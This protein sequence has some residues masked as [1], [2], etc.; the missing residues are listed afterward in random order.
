MSTKRKLSADLEVEPYERPSGGWGSVRSLAR[1]LAGDYVPFTGPRVLLRQNKPDGF[2]C[3]SCAWAKPADPRVFEFCENGAKATTWEIT[4]KRVT[5][6]FFADKTVAE[7]ETWDDHHLEAAGRLTH[8]MRWDAASDKYV[9]VSWEE[10]F[11]EIGRELRAL[12]PDSAV[13]Y[14]SG[15]ASLE[16]SFMYG[17]FARAYG[18]NNLPDS[19]NMCHETTSV[20]LPESIGVPVGTCTLDDFGKTD[21]IF[22]FGQNVGTSSPR[23]LH[24]LQDASRRGV[25]I[26]TFNPLRERGLEEFVNPQAPAEM[27]MGSSTRISSQYHQIKT[28]GDTAAIMGIAK[29]LLAFEGKAN[30]A[31]P[32]IDWNFIRQHT[33][34]WDEFA[35]AVKSCEWAEIER[36]SGLTRNALEAAATVYARAKSVMFI[37][38]MGLTQHERGV[39]TVQTLVNLALM[40][41]NIG[42]PGA[43]ICP[44]RGHSNVQGQRTVG[45]TEKPEM[46]PK[47]KIK[48]LF[49]IDVPAQKGTTTVEAC[50]KIIDGSVRAMVMLGGNLVRSV[51]DHRRVE[52]AWRRLRLTVNI[53][54]KLNRSALVHGEISYIL[55]CLGRIEID[56]QAGVR[57]AVSMEDSTGCMHGSWGQVK[58]ASPDLLSEP[59][60]IAELAK[61][62]APA[63][64]TIPWDD[65]VADYSRIRD[66]I[67]AIYPDIFH[68]FNARLWR[69]GGFHR[70]LGARERRWNTKTGKANFITPGSLATD[71]DTRPEDRDI[72][73]L[74]TLRSNGQFNTTIYNYD[75]RFRGIHGSRQVVL[76]H[77]N[78][79]DRFALKEG[80]VVTLA[81]AANDGVKREVGGLR[82]VAYNI[83]EGCIAG[84]YPECNPLLPLWHHEKKAKTPAA[85]SIPVRVR[86]EAHAA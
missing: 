4:H 57:Q 68:D 10:A 9:P 18:T 63:R 81:T 60:I 20:A 59:R 82:V 72:V 19:S 58:P 85:K 61:A 56:E 66:A 23:M 28:G 38:G 54:T 53:L 55:P 11:T 40:R 29:A 49:G 16:T 26:V 27:L 8:P 21:C 24:E 75:D 77:P 32:V 84:Y 41:G 25:P 64:S 33:H 62:A 30:L 69:P 47:D 73:Q 45:I 70:P 37:Y 43:G 86:A 44:V 34:G 5:A 46:V 12:Q 50:E 67:A 80:S 17:L 14:T 83:P 35:G 7:L 31:Q 39:E 76:M 13:F 74:I 65:W 1:S 15:R 3:V 2:M 51:P 36:R 71:I 78:D 6:A 52:P 42:R 22:F 48:Q 79:I